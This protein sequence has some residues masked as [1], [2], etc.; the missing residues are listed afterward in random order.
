MYRAL[1]DFP[2]LPG[3]V[4]IET[5]FKTS[6]PVPSFPRMWMSSTS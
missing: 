4:L 3:S 1:L 6:R 2:S 5:P